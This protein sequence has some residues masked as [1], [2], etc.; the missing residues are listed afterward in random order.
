MFRMSRSWSAVSIG[1][2]AGRFTGDARRLQRTSATS[3]CGGE[4]EAWGGVSST[5]VKTVEGAMLAQE[6]IV[7]RGS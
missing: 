1:A 4:R 3:S 7:K 6:E 2:L 5:V